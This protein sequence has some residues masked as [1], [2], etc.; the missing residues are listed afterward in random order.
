M[1]PWNIGVINEELAKAFPEREMLVFRDRRLSWGEV[2][3][4]TRRLANVLR[5]AGLGCRRER[6]GLEPWQAGQDHLALYLYNGNEYLE[7][8]LGAFKEIGRA[9]V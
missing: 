6:T 3:G 2:A 8:M 5:G 9:H 4:R 1:K 7:G